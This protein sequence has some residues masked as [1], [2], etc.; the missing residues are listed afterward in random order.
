MGVLDRFPPSHAYMLRE[1]D[2]AMRADFDRFDAGERPGAGEQAVFGRWA[3]LR[4]GLGQEGGHDHPADVLRTAREVAES[5]TPWTA[6]DVG[7]LWEIANGLM[8]LEHTNYLELYRIPLAAIRTLGYSERREIL[9]RIVDWFRKY[10]PPVWEVLHEEIDEVLTEPAEHGPAGVVRTIIWDRDPIAVTLAED[11]GE[12]LADPA[13]LPLL[14][15]W[16][17][18]RSSKPGAR[19][20]TTARSL[21]TPQVAELVREILVLV[22]A[23]RERRPDNGHGTVFLHLCTSVPVRGMVWTCELFDEPWITQ[24]LGDLALTCGVGLGGRGANCRSEML[25]N[26]A[27]NVLAHRG[28]P[29]TVPALARL[30]AKVRKKSVLANVARALDA[31]A[32]RAG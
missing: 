2:E 3:Q 28:G 9:V 30:Q 13:V 11:F 18:A 6:R 19:W 17:T 14:R 8:T 21:L 25:A 22:T 20:L 1:V 24:V 4:L 7:F 10:H 29:D 5:D 26:A 27:V 23:H 31:V 12:R 15:H 16:A 32:E